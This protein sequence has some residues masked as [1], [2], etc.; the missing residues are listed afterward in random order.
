KMGQLYV[1]IRYF[2]VRDEDGEYI[3]TMEVTQN[4]A[5]IKDIEGEKRLTTG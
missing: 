1:Y 2:A 3:G 5:P 4:I